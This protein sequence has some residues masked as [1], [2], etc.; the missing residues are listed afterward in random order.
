MSL[1]DAVD[2]SHI[3]PLPRPLQKLILRG[4]RKPFEMD[5]DQLLWAWRSY[6]ASIT[7]I[8]RQVGRTLDLLNELASVTT[9]LCC[10]V[11]T[12]EIRC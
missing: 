2:I 4:H 5:G 10:S 12:T 6:Y 7:H 11:R 8:D 9:P 1:P 3:E